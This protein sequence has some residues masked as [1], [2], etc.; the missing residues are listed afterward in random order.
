VIDIY[1]YALDLAI[2][3]TSF[4]GK[5]FPQKCPLNL[6]QIL[7]KEFFPGKPLESDLME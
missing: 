4:E 3:E 6:E 7:E 1:E 2:H 5:G